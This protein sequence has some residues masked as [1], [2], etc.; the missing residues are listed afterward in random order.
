MF[1]SKNNWKTKTKAMDVFMFD[2]RPLFEKKYQKRYRVP[3]D[4]E[5]YILRKPIYQGLSDERKE[6]YSELARTAR[7]DAKKEIREERELF[8]RELSRL[9]HE[10]MQERIETLNKSIE[11]NMK[12]SSYPSTSWEDWWADK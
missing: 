7:T 5:L 3:F 12:N 9:Q 11:N 6:Y 10:Y 8:W 4:V 1:V 2:M